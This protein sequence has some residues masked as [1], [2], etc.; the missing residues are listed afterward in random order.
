MPE[1]PEVETIVSE[2]KKMVLK[3]TIFDVWTDAEKII[4]KPKNFN[5]FRK[6]I[7]GKK[8]K[9]IQRRGKNILFYLS[10]AKILLCHLK[11][12]GHFLYGKWE[13][14][15]GEWKSKKR[16]PLNDPMNRFLHLIFFLDNK[17]ML[18]LS[19]LRKF[20]KVELWEKNEFEN[21]KDFL[22]LGPEPLEKEFTLGKFKTILKGKKGRI[23]Q[24]LMN[25][26]V[27]VGIG[28]IYSDEILWKAKVNPF[29]KIN[30]L[31]EKELKEIY[32]AIKKVL[33][34][35]I[36]LKGE[37]ISDYRRVSGKKGF[38]DKERKVYRKTGQKCFRS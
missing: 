13:F 19:D 14:K 37:S 35:A 3:R 4:R 38:F 12:T 10:G 33:K 9:D 24:V 7:S 27:L 1:L 17:N 6:E 5:K 11:M 30:Q 16:G 8:I 29:K 28:N 20:A 2:L 22:K 18:A 32:K 26:E 31:K 15:N 36:Q 25:Q 21:S 34:R 23:K